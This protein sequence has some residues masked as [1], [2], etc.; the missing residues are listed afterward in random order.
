MN[1]DHFA[2]QPDFFPYF[3]VWQGKCRQLG[4]CRD[5]G[6]RRACVPIGLRAF[7]GMTRKPGSHTLIFGYEV[8]VDLIGR[9]MHGH[10]HSPGTPRADAPAAHPCTS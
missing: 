9:K 1:R 2:P 6:Q 10:G 3:P 7:A 4:L 8:L 5:K